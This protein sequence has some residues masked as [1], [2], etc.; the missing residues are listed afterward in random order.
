MNSALFKPAI[1]AALPWEISSNSYHFT[2]VRTYQAPEPSSGVSFSAIRI[3]LTN[4]SGFFRR[5]EK[6]VSGSW[7]DRFFTMLINLSKNSIE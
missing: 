1:S 7:I 2:A 6:T 3:S 4:S 5:A